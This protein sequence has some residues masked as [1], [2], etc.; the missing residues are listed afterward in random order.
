MSDKFE[1]LVLIRED[2]E[3]GIKPDVGKMMP[4]FQRC[5][6]PLKKPAPDYL[7]HIR[8]DGDIKI[9]LEA[10]RRFGMPFGA[11]ILTLL[12]CFTTAMDR[13]SRTLK[14]KAA[15]MILRDMGLP[16][17]T[18][19]YRA[20]VKS[21]ERIFGCKYT[22]EWTEV[23]PRG[24]KKKHLMQAVLF[25]RLSLWF[26]ENDDQ[27]PLEGEGF[28]N[29]IVLSEFA[30]KWLKRTS[31]FETQ[32]AYALR[33]VPGAIQLYFIISS[34]G[35]RLKGPGDLC[36]IPLTGPD[37]LDNQIG[38]V[39][40]E[41]QRMWRKRV[42][43]WLQEIKTGWTDCPAEVVDLTGE[44][45]YGVEKQGWYLRIGWFPQPDHPQN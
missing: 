28:E 25:D 34:R 20:V 26:N 30:W 2:K 5:G 6:F 4:H 11:D 41:N 16:P 32:P 45:R 14:F 13:K 42:K 44:K 35:P 8:H 22:F 33:K 37:G 39:T 29:E 18:Y 27:M 17:Q 31:W 21:F 23:G 3:R 38:G 1:K 9:T 7:E 40:Y 10:S 15:N 19:N 12:W 43:G 36:E 24:W